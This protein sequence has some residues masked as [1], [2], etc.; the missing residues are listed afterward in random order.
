MTHLFTTNHCEGL[1]RL[2]LA[3]C[4]SA[5]RQHDHREYLLSAVGAGYCYL[6]VSRPRGPAGNS[7][8]VCKQANA[9]A[10][11]RTARHVALDMVVLAILVGDASGRQHQALAVFQ[12]AHRHVCRFQNL[13][14]L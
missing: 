9:A 14:N 2:A 11:G 12:F 5:L 13:L 3:E 6:V 8:S 7:G 4:N 10:N 1:D